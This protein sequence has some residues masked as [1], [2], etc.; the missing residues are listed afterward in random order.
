M[1]MDRPKCR[2]API[3]VAAPMLVMLLYAVV[4]LVLITKVP[5]SAGPVFVRYDVRYRYGDT[6]MKWVFW[7]AH[8][9]DRQI[10]PSLWNSP[11]PPDAR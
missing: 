3:L 10:R 8:Q 2:L 7:P 1:G 4:Y 6:A 11:S 5:V 9:L